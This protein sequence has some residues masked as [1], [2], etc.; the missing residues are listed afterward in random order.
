MNEAALRQRR[1]RTHAI[2]EGALLGDIAIV[3]L[4]MR[5]YLP[6]LVLRPILLAFAAVPLVLLMQRRGF[7]ITVL[8]TI[9]CFLLFSALV[10]P[11][12]ALRAV[13][14]GVAAVLVGLGR[15]VGLGA[16]LNT[17]WTGPV[18]AVLDIMIP[19]VATII[20][21]RFPVKDLI[22]TAR[23][24]V[25]V[26]FN[27]LVNIMN[28]FHASAGTI[29]QARQWEKYTADHW[30]LA[31]VLVAI[32]YATLTMYLVALVSDAVLNQIPEQ[33]QSRQKAA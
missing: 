28:R 19:T 27:L 1:E 11:L 17:L 18:Y 6:I 29:H 10:G 20:L 3:F 30:Q 26:A 9:A 15:K 2:V 8:A 13:D 23:H 4:L 16:G 14:I 12:L 24:S 33:T 5:A 32:L 21:F 25:E 22:T 7:R 31:W